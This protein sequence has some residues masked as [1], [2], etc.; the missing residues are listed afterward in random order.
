MDFI[1]KWDIYGKPVTFYYNT[2]TVHKTYFGA[3]LSILSFSLMMTITI[4]SFYNFLYQKPAV[5]SNI[6][7]FINKK[8]AQLEAMAIKGKLSMDETEDTEQIDEFVKYFR[9]VL[10]EKYFDEVETFNV[11]KLVKV[12]SDYVFNVTMS[13]SDVFKEKE[14]SSLKIMSCNDI[15]KKSEVN[16]ASQFNETTCDIHYQKYL[17]KNYKSNSYLL[18]FDA[19]NYTIDRKGRLRQVHI[20]TN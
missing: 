2:S 9:I 15:K 8:F 17:S 10:H 20:K 18:S 12:G 11:A 6:V 7:Y 1:K 16:W 14:F 5:S 19:P 3:L 4:T 13:I